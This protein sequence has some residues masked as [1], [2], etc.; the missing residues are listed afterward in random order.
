[1]FGIT[2]SSTSALSLSWH[3]NATECICE[4]PRSLGSTVLCWWLPLL[5]QPQ[6]STP[7]SF[8]IQNFTFWFSSYLNDHTCIV[9]ADKESAKVLE[10]VRQVIWKKTKRGWCHRNQKKKGVVHVIK[11]WSQVRGEKK[12]PCEITIQ[13]AIWRSTKLW[14]EWSQCYVKRS[15]FGGG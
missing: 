3:H 11:Y 2:N 12:Q 14:Q 13:L 8:G 1:M 15:L 6:G 7:P 4:V 9:W 5:I 10:I